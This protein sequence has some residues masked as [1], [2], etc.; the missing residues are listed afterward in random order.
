MKVA[1]TNDDVA[2][3][4]VE[5]GA[6]RGFRQNFLSLLIGHGVGMGSNEPPYV[7]ESLPGAETVELQRSAT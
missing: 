6:L 2:D 4:V 1:N 3:L 5:E 7:G